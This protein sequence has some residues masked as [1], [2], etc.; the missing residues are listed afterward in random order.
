L[1]TAIF[2][3][4]V[5]LSASFIGGAAAANGQ[6]GLPA[7]NNLLK[8][9]AGGGIAVLIITFFLFQLLR[10]NPTECKSVTALEIH[11]IPASK[12]LPWVQDKFWYK[13]S[14]ERSQ[15]L[16]LIVQLDSEGLRGAI[17]IPVVDDKGNEIGSCKLQV[18]FVA[19]MDGITDQFVNQKV[20]EIDLGSSEDTD[21]LL[22]FVGS[23]PANGT[24]AVSPNCVS[25]N[26]IPVENFIAICP[27]SHKIM[28]GIPKPEALVDDTDFAPVDDGKNTFSPR[29]FSFGIVADAYAALPDTYTI[30]FSE[31]RSRLLSPSD[32]IRV[33]ARQL[34]ESHFKDYSSE[35]LEEL[36]NRQQDD[37]DYVSSLISGLIVGI[38]S[39][40]VPSGSLAPDQPRNLA[41]PL[42]YVT[43]HESQIINF[44]GFKDDSVKQQARRLVARFPFDQFK[45]KYTDIMKRAASGACDERDTIADPAGIIYSGIFYFY[46]RI[47]QKNYAPTLSNA[48]VNEIEL[49][50]KMVREAANHCL[51]PELSTDAALV[52][53]GAAIVYH[54]DKGTDHS[55]NA[56]AAAKDFLAAVN[57]REK[58]YFYQVQIGTIKKL[59]PDL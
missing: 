46:N 39:A 38:D 12:S 34:L 54:E 13:I 3:L 44:N 30:S 57:G 7:Q 14:Q 53:F 52:D 18:F 50:R 55:I 1:L 40:A 49:V 29:R 43:G 2:A 4:G 59:F 17:E 21:V 35:A 37:G 20:K 11:N 56:K 58:L 26:Q 15:N 47:A 9:S 33:Q 24:K 51:P 36:F 32:T 5:A 42:P 16:D 23:Q 27:R 19:R 8:Y 48:D 6:L 22:E 28:F 10:P 25:Y 45:G 31:L 41:M